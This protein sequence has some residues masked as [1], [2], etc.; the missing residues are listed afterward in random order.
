MDSA[1]KFETV[2]LI[3]FWPCNIIKFLQ[4]RLKILGF[5]AELDRSSI[6][7]EIPL[8]FIVVGP[9]Y[10]LMD[11][12]GD[13]ALCCHN[14]TSLVY[15]HNNIRD[16]LGHSAKAAGLAAVVTEKK[17]RSRAR[18]QSLATSP[19]SSTIVALRPPLLTLPSLTIAE[20]IY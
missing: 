2:I 1:V 12:F 5:L 8:I 14:G 10:V 15:R 17:T 19:C 11:V 6:P 9:F 7:E 16:I 3:K 20:K 13:H 18:T 4:P